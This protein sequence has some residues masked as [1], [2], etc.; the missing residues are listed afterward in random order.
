M[1]TNPLPYLALLVASTALAQAS[2]ID[3]ADVSR[4]LTLRPTGAALVDQATAPSVNPAGLSY[5]G[6]FELDYLHERNLSLSSTNDGLFVGNTFGHLGLG[7]SMEWLRPAFQP[8]Y[9][10][11][12][13][14]ASLGGQLLSIGGALRFYSSDVSELDKITT[15]DLGLVTR[16]YR[17]LSL[18]ATFL[19]LDQR[20]EGAL[21]FHRGYDFGIG[22]RPIG[23]RFTLGADYLFNE[24]A[25]ADNG[26]V[27]GT[28]GLTVLPGLNL[29]AGV[30][31]GVG[32]G[33]DWR[34][35]VALTIDAEHA[36][37]T[38]AGGGTKTGAD[39]VIAVRLSA[40]EFRPL[41]LGGGKL[42]LFDLDDMLQPPGGLGSLL[43]FTEADPYIR[44]MRRL[45]KAARDPDLAGVVLKVNGLPN[46]S[47][48][49]AEELRQA[50]LRLRTSGKRVI[51]VLLSAGDPEYLAIASAD[52]IETVPQ[53]LLD[54]NGLAM[55]AVFLGGTME[56]F[57]VHWDVAKVGAYK[58][59]P[60]SLTRKTMTPEQREAMQAFLDSNT[61]HFDDTVTQA[62]K[63]SLAELNSALDEGLIPPNDAKTHKLVDDVVSTSQLN[64]ELERLIPGAS[65]DPG[66][67]KGT[68]RETRWG[69]RRI[70]AIV[71]ILGDI[72]GGKSR[73]SPTGG[74]MAGAETVVL[75]IK[76]AS[77]DPR[78]AAIV[79]RI[80]SPGGDGLASD[81]IYR[82]VLEAKKK[83][84]VIASMGDLAASGGYYSAMGA[85]LIY[86]LP[87]TLTGSIGVFALKPA[88]EGLAHKLDAN[89]ETLK[90]RPLATMFSFYSPWS[91][92]EQKAAQH[93]VDAFYDDFITGVSDSRRLP[94][95]KV[96]AI[97]RGRIW[98]GTDALARGLVDKLGGLLD[99]V[100]EARRRAGIARAED[101]ELEEFG[102]AH[103]IFASMGGEPEVLAKLIPLPTTGEQLG[104]LARSLGIDPGMLDQTG[105]MA[106][107]PYDVKLR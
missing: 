76:R 74:E 49:K 36:G 95:D 102:E 89:V 86:A 100:D 3:A 22:L 57:G 44:L 55:S 13:W 56:D 77:M 88:F 99:A 28:L 42:A 75:A 27:Q 8:H 30:A 5:V 64:E 29:G 38:Y 2:N 67:L 32:A 12:S 66:Y 58:N 24:A 81:L 16:P 87:T 35:Q 10:R 68:P 21:T 78:V 15:F 80:D 4:G 79:L 11:T 26:V 39:H 69:N 107:L 83:K 96:D 104:Q 84:P 52:R 65:Y 97:A 18:G 46:V 6:D 23:E 25:G 1:R 47:V 72:I 31:K 17:W 45:D 92:Q 82:E 101:V 33:G 62:R 61:R 34:F 40:D 94:K 60:D 91:E 14:S 98:S 59:A 51:A 70:I 73:Q 19:N 37:L 105:V 53:A 41:T 93:W 103:G 50:I 85:D 71:P 54:V 9:R 7:F 43:G 48:G 106:R 90:S 63:I 20:S